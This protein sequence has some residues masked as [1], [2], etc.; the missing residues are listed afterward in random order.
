MIWINILEYVLYDDLFNLKQTDSF[1]KE[2]CDNELREYDERINQEFIQKNINHFSTTMK[3]YECDDMCK[4]IKDLCKN[5]KI[6]L[7]F[8]TYNYNHSF[9]RNIASNMECHIKKKYSYFFLTNS[10]YDFISDATVMRGK[11]NCLAISNIYHHDYDFIIQE[12]IMPCL[13]KLNI[14]HRI[15]DFTFIPKNFN[16]NI[17][18]CNKRLRIKLKFRE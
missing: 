15:D 5:E 8:V 3:N 14:N 18:G 1:F 2:I 12:K 13:T 10:I 9:N 16:I 11:K 4:I 7:H 6:I 17:N